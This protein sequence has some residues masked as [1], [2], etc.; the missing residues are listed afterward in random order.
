VVKGRVRNYFITGMV[1]VLPIIISVWV[2]TTVF[3][4]LT[5]FLFRM[6]QF[7]HPLD[8]FSIGLLARIGSLVIIFFAVIVIGVLARNVFGK[9]IVHL[10]DVLCTK[11]PVFGR[12]YSATRQISH[13][14]I[15]EQKTV[16]RKVVLIRYPRKSLFTVAFLTSEIRGEAQEKTGEDLINVFIPTSPNPTS[17][18]LIMVPRTDVIPLDM[19]IEDGM[20]LV[21]SGGAFVPPFGGGGGW[22]SPGAI[23]SEKEPG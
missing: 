22:S 8:S 9:K 21:I 13:A 5:N 14:F 11:I 15:G 23:G 1:I 10:I 17:G 7:F 3:Y 6:I 19:S 16:F 4:I 18:M 20:K 2:F 12:V